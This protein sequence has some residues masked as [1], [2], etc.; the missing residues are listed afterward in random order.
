M[1]GYGNKHTY[2]YVHLRHVQHISETREELGD[3]WV[4]YK[5]YHNLLIGLHSKPE[6]GVNLG[7]IMSFYIICN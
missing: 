3:L 2:S 5:S 1:E 6:A 4:D 7:N